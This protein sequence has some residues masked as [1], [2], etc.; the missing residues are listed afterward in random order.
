MFCLQVDKVVKVFKTV[1]Q[2]PSPT[3]ARIMNGVA[4]SN[5]VT[6]LSSWS[7]KNLERGKSVKFQQ[8][9]IIDSSFQKASDMLPV[10][11]SFEYVHVHPVVVVHVM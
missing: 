1:G 4:G 5:G 2:Y 9:H 10:D 8:I 11:T 7:Q 3:A 6:I